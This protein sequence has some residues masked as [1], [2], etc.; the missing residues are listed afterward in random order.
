MSST[1]PAPW[2]RASVEPTYRSTTQISR[3]HATTARNNRHVV[4]TFIFA[5]PFRVPDSV[6]AGTQ[7]R[8]KVLP[9]GSAPTLQPDANT[10][11]GDQRGK[12]NDDQ[13]HS[14]PQTSAAHVDTFGTNTVGEE[15][16][17]AALNNRDLFSFKPADF[18]RHLDLLRPIY[19]K[20][21]NYGHFGR[22]ED[23][24]ALTWEK[25]EHVDELKSACQ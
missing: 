4:A 22:E 2:R 6:R 7:N 8:G 11:K 15:K 17:E 9:T 3:P 13:E 1:R 23:T 25:T 10:E 24:D 12:R 18:I 14:P 19:R 21:T 20:S 16:I 5:Y